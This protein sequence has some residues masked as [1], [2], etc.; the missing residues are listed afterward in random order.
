MTPA[1]AQK[2]FALYSQNDWRAT[3]KLTINLGLRWD[4]QPG[5]TE[6]YNRFSS[7]DFTQ[8]NPFGTL[9][10]IAFPGSNGYGRN[11]WDTEY[12]DFGPRIGAA[13]RVAQ[14]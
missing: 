2:Y 5:P 6:R 8:K 14:G 3:S 1:L 10:A 11:L 7:Y 9:G 4:L 13:Y 12:H